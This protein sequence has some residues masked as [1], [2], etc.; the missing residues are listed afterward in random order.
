MHLKI[1]SWNVWGLND[2]AKRRVIKASLRRWNPH[3]VCFQETKMQRV[4]R[5]DSVGGG[6]WA[7]WEH[8]GA[9][10]AAGGILVMWDSRVVS[11]M[12][13]I[14]GV[15]SVSCLLK[16]VVN[17]KVWIYSGVYGPCSDTC[18]LEL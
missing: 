5:R 3:V 1:I 7:E 16:I 17:D 6:R 11:K 8:F 18:R 14:V 13:T 2:L 10:G 12:G 4:D 15:H 9:E